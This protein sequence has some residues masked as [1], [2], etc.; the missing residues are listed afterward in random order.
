MAPDTALYVNFKLKLN[1]TV[2][3]NEAKEGPLFGNS[4][5]LF[6]HS[7][8]YNHSSVTKESNQGLETMT[9]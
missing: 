2:E 5:P 6:R 8:I 7:H 4:R 9:V 3:E 1:I